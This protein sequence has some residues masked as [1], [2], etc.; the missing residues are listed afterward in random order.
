MR[1]SQPKQL[2]FTPQQISADNYRPPL[3]VTL[4][5]IL[6]YSTR[7]TAH[8]CCAVTVGRDKLRLSRKIMTMYHDDVVTTLGTTA[9]QAYQFHKLARSVVI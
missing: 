9:K 6:T 8:M 2:H 5:F 4:F 7:P 3:P 1:I